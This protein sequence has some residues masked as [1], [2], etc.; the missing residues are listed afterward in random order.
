MSERR[1]E[2]LIP[3]RAAD[4][5]ARRGRPPARAVLPGMALLLALS[6]APVATAQGPR[7][8]GLAESY[9]Q[10]QEFGRR[11]ESDEATRD[12]HRNVLLPEFSQRYR[13]HFRECT[14]T[15][16]QPESTPFSFVAAI[17]AD[18]KVQRVWSDRS[19]NVFQCVRGK[20]LFDRFSP[21]PRAP[22]Y[23]YIH[24]RFTN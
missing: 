17:G 2:A 1:P 9:V 4:S 22:F 24:M 13:A 7:A 11:D 16:P 20:L 15:V 14:A 21:P 18:G 19:T 6:V 5:L 12:Y 3:Q 8:D 23:L 10:A